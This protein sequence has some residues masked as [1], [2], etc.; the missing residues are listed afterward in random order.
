MPLLLY[1][2][3]EW[4]NKRIKERLVMKVTIELDFSADGYTSKEEELLCLK[5]MLEDLDSAAVTIRVNSLEIIKEFK[6]H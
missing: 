4:F 6:N 5:E 1:V 2:L 3:E